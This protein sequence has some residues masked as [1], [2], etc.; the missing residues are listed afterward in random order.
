MK[1]VKLKVIKNE[2]RKTVTVVMSPVIFTFTDYLYEKYEG[3]RYFASGI[4]QGWNYQEEVLPAV[5][6]ILNALNEVGKGVLPDG[7]KLTGKDLLTLKEDEY[8]LFGKHLNKDK[9]WDKQFQVNLASKNKNPD[10]RF[11]FKDLAGKMQVPK[12]DGW[13][14]VY[15][16]E[17]EIGA[18]YNEDSLE[19]YV[20]TVFHRAIAL[21]R[22]DVGFQSN[23]EAWEGFDF[24]KNEEEVQEEQVTENEDTNKEDISTA[25]DDL[26]DSDDDLP[27]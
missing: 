4:L 7:E 17:I 11:L 27:F 14:Y 8:R 16:I 5:K 21:K 2:S 22:R 6:K 9:E 15:A 18:G 12:E 23:N 24:G 20:F 13:K 10:K 1:K 26:I 3:K 25:D 19:K